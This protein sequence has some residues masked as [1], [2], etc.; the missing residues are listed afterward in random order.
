MDA[1]ISILIQNLQDSYFNTG[2]T[3]ACPAGVLNVFISA[4]GGGG[5]GGGGNTGGSAGAGEG[6]RQGNYNTIRFPVTPGNTYAVAVGAG[7]SAVGVMTTGNTGGDTSF[8][9]SVV[10]QGGQGG[11]Q[12]WNL[13][14]GS[15]DGFGGGVGAGTGGTGGTGGGG[16]GASPGVTSGAGGGGYLRVFWF[17]PVL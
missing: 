3:W 14:A 10:A 11:Q 7:G 13:V 17:V 9:G 6:G 12:M 8:N 5:G 4:K 15:G 16:A 2:G 1:G